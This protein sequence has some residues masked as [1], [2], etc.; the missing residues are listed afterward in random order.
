MIRLR[1]SHDREIVA[2]AL[3]ALGAL[4]ADPLLSLV[5]TAFV[6]RIGTD[7]LGGL[8]V[9]T[10]L[11]TVSFFLFNFLEYGTTTVVARAVGAG[12]TA[13][14][15]RAVVTA[16]TFAA[17]GGGVV[18]FVLRGFGED[19]I[20]AFGAN[21]EVAA[22]AVEYVRVRALAAPAVL[23][24]RV[25]HGAYRGYQ[26]TRTPFLVAVG[27]N[28]VNLVLD[29]LLIFGAGWGVAGAA[30]ATVIAQWGGAAAFL[31]LFARGRRRYGLAGARPVA[32]EVRSF[33]VVGRDL[34]IRTTALMVAFTLATSVATRVSDTAIAAHQ[35]LM[36]VFLFTALALDAFAIAAQAVVGRLLGAG[37]HRE[38]TEVADR[39]LVLGVGAGV[40]AGVVLLMLAPFLPGWFGADPPVRR[41]VEGILW[42]VA[43]LQPLGAVVWVLDGVFIGAGDFR[44]LAG[45][46]VAA[47]ALAAGVMLAVLPLGW[48]LSGVWWGIA[49]LLVVRAI[50]LAWRRV[51]PRGPFRSPP[52]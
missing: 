49:T 24:M 16:L 6:G 52:G 45:A 10:A 5:D 46:M 27:V 28:L 17:C 32:G 4:I 48:G 35:V 3:P 15:G 7:A 42:V 39:L 38:A 37:R 19:I 43:L 25:G 36:Q 18:V 33:L 22:A 40:V 26:N 51:S 13:T 41:A 50:T 1:S 30:W 14:A 34:A 9:A 21:G 11:F 20:G 44:Y 2:L 29:P 12:Q 47:S 8:G 31:V 23:L